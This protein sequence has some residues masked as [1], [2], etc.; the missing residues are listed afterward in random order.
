MRGPARL[1]GK[2]TAGPGCWEWTAARDADGYGRVGDYGK[3]RY[4]HRVMYER[5]AGPVPEGLELDHLCRNRACVRPDHLEAVTR[6]E[7]CLRSPIIG[8][9]AV[10][11]DACPNGHPYDEAN[12][13]TG[14]GFRTCRA[15]RAA[16]VRR[17]R[18]RKRAAA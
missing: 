6:R 2:Y 4:A 10:E 7:N 14:R 17:M 16:R 5:E 11:K 9:A 12:T 3:N 18:A 13:H 15:C 1:E 8:R